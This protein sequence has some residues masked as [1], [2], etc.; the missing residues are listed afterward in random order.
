MPSKRQPSKQRRAAKNRAARA[1]RAA[2]REHAGT[3]TEEALARIGEDSL[4]SELGSES[5]EIGSGS[6]NADHANAAATTNGDP[7]GRPG[8]LL[9]GLFGGR[10]GPGVGDPQPPQPAQ[11][12]N[13]GRSPGSPGA[14]VRPGA[15]PPGA[16]AALF[17]VAFALASFGLLLFA[18]LVSVDDRGEVI[19]RNF[20]AVY[21][22]ARS[23]I[24]TGE[25]GR[26]EA[27]ET[28]ILD[29]Y[30][31]MTLLLYAV[32]AL[33]AVVAYAAHKRTGIS[34]PLTIGML[35]L[36]LGVFITG[37]FF[38]PSL[39]AMAIASFQARKAE[40]P[41]RVAQ[42]A[43]REGPDDSAG[44]QDPQGPDDTTTPDTEIR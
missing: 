15:R 11:P 21:L 3:L 30:G 6:S 25:F 18:S 37:A 27:T 42:R 26:V 4:S 44:P 43:A 29:A 23:L 35:G 34:R 28:T 19:P 39:I 17:A 7:T 33:I 38:M 10:R 9:S 40:L 8:G 20:G 41:A 32:P 16:R 13:A 12:D 36:A 2:R 14:P 5:P 1:A 31:P 22:E 24:T